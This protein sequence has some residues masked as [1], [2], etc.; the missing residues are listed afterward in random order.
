LSLHGVR[1]LIVRTLPASPSLVAVLLVPLHPLHHC[2]APLLLR[3]PKGKFGLIEFGLWRSLGLRVLER[4]SLDSNGQLL[5]L[6]ALHAFP[7]TMD[8]RID[9]ILLLIIVRVHRIAL[10]LL[11]CFHLVWHNFLGDFLRLIGAGS[12]LLQLVQEIVAGL[13]L[14]GFRTDGWHGLVLSF[15]SR[16]LIV[17]ILLVLNNNDVL[18]DDLLDLAIFGLPPFT[19]LVFFLS[20]I[21]GI[22]RVFLPNLRILL[23]AVFLGWGIIL[24]HLDTFLINA[25]RLVDRLPLPLGIEGVPLPLGHLQPPTHVN[26]L[27]VSSSLWTLVLQPSLIIIIHRIIMEA[28][29]IFHNVSVCSIQINVFIIIGIILR[30]HFLLDFLGPIFLP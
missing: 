26:V 28:F 18:I 12:L 17:L 5:V 16:L 8:D 10:V 2:L 29:I 7:L 20:L 4:T 11:D 27:E 23:I 24:Y 6:F 19:L 9:H 14:V 30:R 1:D 15:L 22:Q 13:Q 25:S 3:I 21:D